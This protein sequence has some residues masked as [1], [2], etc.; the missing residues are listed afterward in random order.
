MDIQNILLV[1]KF[2]EVMPY[3]VTCPIKIETNDGDGLF[4]KKVQEIL[5]NFL[6]KLKGKL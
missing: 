1:N 5:Y 3:G 6:E 4:Y 2:I